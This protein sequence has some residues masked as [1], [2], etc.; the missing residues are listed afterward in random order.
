MMREPD[1]QKRLRIAVLNRNFS[2]AAGGAE[3]YSVAL[4]EQL[5]ARHEFH[6]FA[7]HIDHQ[8]PGVTYHKVSH[9]FNRPRWINQLWYATCTWWATRRGFDV[10]HSHEITWHGQVQ[11]VHVLPIYYNLFN[12]RKGRKFFLRWLKLATSPRLLVYVWLEHFRFAQKPRR[13]I[14]ATSGSLLKTMRENYPNTSPMLKILSPGVLEVPGLASETDKRSARQM[15]VLPL[16]GPVILFVANDYRK[17]GLGG[18][19]LAL[20][21][22]SENVVLAVVGNTVQLSEFRTVVQELGLAARVFFLGSMIDM[23]TVYRAADFLVHP[24]QEDTFAMVVLEAMA[25]G[26]PVVVTGLPY[27]GISGLLTDGI[28]ALIV[29][30]P[31]NL[32]LLAAKI[33]SLLSSESLRHDLGSAAI[34]FVQQH[35][36]SQVAQKQEQIYWSS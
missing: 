16:S 26:L 34:E 8:W 33:D 25:H 14:V 9:P 23:T 30:R 28:N 35:L 4:V 12:G 19:L 18:L 31:D 15:L 36:W 20:S 2:T 3:R 10:V 6:V 17:K 27:C 24:T 29:D 11:T 32:A 22:L 1:P 13:S 7:Q 21:K 5:A